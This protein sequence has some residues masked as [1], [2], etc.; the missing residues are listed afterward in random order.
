MRPARRIAAQRESIL[1]RT[2]VERVVLVDRFRPKLSQLLSA[3]AAARLDRRVDTGDVERR[4]Q[5]RQVGPEA[6]AV[7]LARGGIVVAPEGD[8]AAGGRH[9]QRARL[10]RPASRAELE[11]RGVAQESIH[12]S[13]ERNMKC[14][15]GLCGHCQLG[16][17]FVCR[18]GPVLA[19]PRL[20]T[21]IDVPEL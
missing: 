21:L 8:A 15:C 19:W 1:A 10:E 17:H 12:V 5:R 16:P 13:L 6:P 9:G 7:R 18:D 2:D 3:Q 4:R 14:G 20:K 11:R